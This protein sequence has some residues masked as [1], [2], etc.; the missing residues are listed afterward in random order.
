MHLGL[1]TY[2]LTSWSARNAHVVTPFLELRNM[3][4]CSNLTKILPLDEKIFKIPQLCPVHS[5]NQFWPILWFLSR[6]KIAR[7]LFLV[8]IACHGDEVIRLAKTLHNSHS[9]KE[10]LLHV[11]IASWEWSWQNNSLANLRTPSLSGRDNINQPLYNTF[12]HISY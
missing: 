5:C 10:S 7:Y 4:V 6:F 11:S 8:G 1:S 9:I 12:K 2:S 3:D